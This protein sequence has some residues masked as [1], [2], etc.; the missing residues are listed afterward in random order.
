M[1]QIVVQFLS[2]LGLLNFQSNGGIGPYSRPRAHT[3]RPSDVSIFFYLYGIPL[4]ATFVMFRFGVRMR[5]TFRA[6]KAI[7]FV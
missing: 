7:L 1:I 3:V 4:K 2:Y 5:L 6:Q